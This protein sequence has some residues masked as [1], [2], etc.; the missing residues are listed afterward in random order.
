MADTNPF[1]LDA[2]TTRNVPAEVVAQIHE[3]ADTDGKS[4][5]KHHTLG[6]KKFQASPGDHSHDGG[7]SAIIYPLDGV[8]ITGSRSGGTALVSIIDALVKLG[9]SNGTTA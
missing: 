3:K 4:T 1:V 6:P 5:A 8:T 9:A 7:S 2:Q